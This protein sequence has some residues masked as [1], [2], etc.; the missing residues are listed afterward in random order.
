MTRG[1]HIISMYTPGASVTQYPDMDASLEG[2]K[3]KIS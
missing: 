3:G 2:R 1:V